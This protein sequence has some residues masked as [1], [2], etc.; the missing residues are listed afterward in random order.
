MSS[1]M[2]YN[3]I[4]YVLV[5]F[6]CKLTCLVRAVVCD[7]AASR[8]VRLCLRTAIGEVSQT[9]KPLETRFPRFPTGFHISGNPWKHTLPVARGFHGFTYRDTVYVNVM[10]KHLKTVKY[11]INITI[12]V[13]IRRLCVHMSCKPS[14]SYLHTGSV[15]SR[16]LWH[17]HQGYLETHGNPW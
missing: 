17:L 9:W 1:T 6:S 4:W 14:R 11:A 15:P 10:V 16:V 12:I 5:C 2:R 13:D 3:I 7:F 8:V